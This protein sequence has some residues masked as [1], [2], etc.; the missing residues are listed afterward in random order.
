MVDLTSVD[1]A[2]GATLPSDDLIIYE[3]ECVFR[4]DR[5]IRVDCTSGAVDYS[6]L[7]YL[8]GKHQMPLLIR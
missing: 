4:P 8:K 5:P 6:Q 3:P 7:V 2:D 1:V